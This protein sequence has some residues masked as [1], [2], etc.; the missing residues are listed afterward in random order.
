MSMSR[1]EDII[2]ELKMRDEILAILKERV[3]NERIRSYE[4]TDELYLLARNATVIKCGN[5]YLGTGGQERTPCDNEIWKKYK[6][7]I[8]WDWLEETGEDRILASRESYIYVENFATHMKDEDIIIKVFI[9]T[10]NEKNKRKGDITLALQIDSDDWGKIWE[11]SHMKDIVTLY[12]EDNLF[13]YL[14]D[15]RD[16]SDRKLRENT[17]LLHK[18]NLATSK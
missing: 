11:H 5:V 18:L 13:S 15:N 8:D 9:A 10:E 1:E 14:W 16:V 6:D 12:N 7:E 3:G 2:K 4:T 17:I